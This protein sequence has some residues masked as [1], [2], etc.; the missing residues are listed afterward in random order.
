[1]AGVNK[2]E[3]I[4]DERGYQKGGGPKGKKERALPENLTVCLAPEWTEIP[5]T[6]CARHRWRLGWAPREKNGE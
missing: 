5:M 6:R 2:K 3:E 1:M 4:S